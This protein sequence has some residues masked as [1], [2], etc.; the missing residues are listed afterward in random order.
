MAIRCSS[1]STALAVRSTSRQEW[2]S[3]HGLKTDS[4]SSSELDSWPQPSASQTTVGRPIHTKKWATPVGHS[5]ASSTTQSDSGTTLCSSR[6]TPRR[7]LWQSERQSHRRHSHCGRTSVQAMWR[8]VTCKAQCLLWDTMGLYTTESLPHTTRSRLTG[9][10]SPYT[11]AWATI[12]LS[13]YSHPP[14]WQCVPVRGVETAL[15]WRW[16]HRSIVPTHST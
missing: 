3:A 11:A 7:P 8:S 4:T 6:T 15:T 5:L 16:R 2:A 9:F 1:L 12:F 10:G 13:T 14:R